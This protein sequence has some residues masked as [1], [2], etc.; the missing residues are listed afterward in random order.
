M[1]YNQVGIEE[2]IS[3]IHGKRQFPWVAYEFTAH[4]YDALM[5]FVYTYY[6]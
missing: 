5:S 6:Y 1:Y 4:A 3:K 2:S